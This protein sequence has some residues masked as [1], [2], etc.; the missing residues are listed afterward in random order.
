MPPLYLLM[1]R[2]SVDRLHH[3]DRLQHGYI[4]PQTIPAGTVGLS[5]QLDVQRLY[6]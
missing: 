1:L 6:H 3:V 2:S 5:T 4:T